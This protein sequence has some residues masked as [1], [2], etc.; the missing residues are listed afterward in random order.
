MS[1][2]RKKKIFKATKTFMHFQKYQTA[3]LNC[4]RSTGQNGSNC[5]RIMCILTL[6]FGSFV[7]IF[8]ADLSLIRTEIENIKKFM[9]G[10]IHVLNIWPCFSLQSEAS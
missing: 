3:S 9:F 10:K 2:A 4:L 5:K 6:L 7:P 1:L 8:V